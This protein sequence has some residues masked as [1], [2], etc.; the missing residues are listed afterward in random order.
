MAQSVRE[1][2]QNVH[3]D[4]IL[5]LIDF[6]IEEIHSNNRRRKKLR[7]IALFQWKTTSDKEE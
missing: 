3:I 2:I 6:Q 4:S 7:I 5:F 1:E